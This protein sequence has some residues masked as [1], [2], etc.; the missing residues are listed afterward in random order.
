MALEEL[1]L[2]T[3]EVLLYFSMGVL[4]WLLCH[5]PQRQAMVSFLAVRYSKVKISSP[6]N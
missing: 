1:S 4:V 5:A 3:G 6:S 2:D